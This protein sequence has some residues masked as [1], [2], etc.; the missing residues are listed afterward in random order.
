MRFIFGIWI[1]PWDQCQ[2]LSEYVCVVL[3]LNSVFYP[4]DLQIHFYGNTNTLDYH[5]FR[6]NFEI[7]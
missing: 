1:L 7:R 6:V 5:N 2:N 3:F 4:T